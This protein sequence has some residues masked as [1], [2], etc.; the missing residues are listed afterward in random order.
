LNDGGNTYKMVILKEKNMDKLDVLI[1]GGATT[2]CYLARHLGEK[3]FKVKVIEKKSEGKVGKYDIFHIRKEDFDVYNIPKTK[4]GD[5]IWAFEFEDNNTSSPSNKINIPTKDGIVGMHMPEY[6]NL[7]AN[8]AKEVGAE[9]VY[10]ADFK[11]LVYENGK[12][13]GVKYTK[14]GQEII[15]YAKIVA[16]CSGMSAVARTALPATYG[17]ENNKLGPNDMFY[18]ILRYILLDDPDGFG[19]INNSWP[20]YKTWI[21]PASDIGPERIYGI[22][23]CKSFDYAEEQYKRFEN[24]MELAK[25]KEFRKEYGTT[26]YT[27]PPY[28]LVSDNFIVCGDAG[29]L[30][31]PLNGEGVTSS[32]T[33]ILVI[34]DVLEKLLKENKTSKKDL[35]IINKLYNE[36]QGGDFVFLRALLIKVVKA[37]DSEFEYFFTKAEKTLRVVL[38]NQPLK[39]KHIMNAAGTLIGGILTGK[40]S[41]STIGGAVSGLICGIKLKNHYVA[42]PEDPKDF[43]KWVKKADKLWDK[44]GKIT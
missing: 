15:D 25:G 27:R 29:N 33:Q 24:G 20:N 18:V 3:G 28:S 35:W 37:K 6:I 34:V 38:N 7:L 16:D 12:I 4:K 19:K 8:W 31:K 44:V 17:I 2:G 21:A 23:A 39:F 10:D 13:V 5:G 30:T 22:G 41:L 11:E 9:F 32:M 1:I 43:D 14:D 36:K 42:F 40:V 26:P